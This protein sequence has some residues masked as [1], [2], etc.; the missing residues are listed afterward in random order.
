MPKSQLLELNNLPKQKMLE[1][2]KYVGPMPN[3]NVEAI[4][5]NNLQKV[6]PPMM[7]PQVGILHYGPYN[8]ANVT[9]KLS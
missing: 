9:P 6:N 4:N 7:N 5:H 1:A 8:M 3:N 2:V